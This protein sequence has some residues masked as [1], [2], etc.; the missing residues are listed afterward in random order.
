MTVNP[1]HL[2][3]SYPTSTLGVSFDKLS[4]VKDTLSMGDWILRIKTKYYEDKDEILQG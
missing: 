3:V 2:T 4:T 1:G